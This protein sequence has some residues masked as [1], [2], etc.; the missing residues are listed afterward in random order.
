MVKRFIIY[1]TTNLINGKYYIGRHST[2]NINDGYLGSGV[3]LRNAIKK[4]GKE[5]FKRE[6]I[7][8][9]LNSEYLWEL[10][11]EI[12]TKEMLTDPMCYNMTYGGKNH[13]FELSK[14]DP[15][16]FTKHQSR[17]GKIGG[18]TFLSNLSEKEKRNWHR[19]GGLTSHIKNKE[20]KSH[21]FYNGSASVLGGKS[22]VGYI[23][24]WNPDSKTTNKN[25]ENYKSGDCRR[26]RP[27]SELYHTLV[28]QNWLPIKEHKKKLQE[29]GLVI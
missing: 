26:V 23:E 3:A 12:I 2:E 6:I 17:A 8:E 28:S 18:K 14:Q 21:P 27:N 7:L 20:N 4:Y 19:S 5:N 11:R 15:E 24:L 16:K 25:Q 9:A 10:E 1:K 29:Q 13:L 22:L